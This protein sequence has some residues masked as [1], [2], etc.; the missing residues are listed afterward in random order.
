[1]SSRTVRS[2]S[3]RIGV[4]RTLGVIA[5][6][7]LAVRAFLGVIWY[8]VLF[9]D[10]GPLQILASEEELSVFLEVKWLVRL[11]NPLASPR[12]RQVHAEQYWIHYDGRSWRDPVKVASDASPTFH[13]NIMRIMRYQ[14]AFY[15]LCEAHFE[16]PGRAYRWTGDR[17]VPLDRGEVTE[18]FKAVGL[19][20]WQ[21]DF[22]TFV[23][24]VDRQ[25]EN[26]GWKVVYRSGWPSVWED[27]VETD[28][29]FEWKGRWYAIVERMSGQMATYSIV[30]PEDSETDVELVTFDTA[31]H[32]IS[33]RDWRK[34]M[35]QPRWWEK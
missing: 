4:L 34:L 1:M 9:K 20:V 22:S 14:G 12:V 33:E 32:R 13:P 16:Q 23:A 31:E 6:I 5:C 18:L 30:T 29:R 17:F 27:P 10:L 15:L 28:C 24:K 7:A 26:S 35:S 11:P 19:D 25:T 8:K 2:K 21:A 3:G